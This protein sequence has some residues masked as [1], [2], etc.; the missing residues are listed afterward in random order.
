MVYYESQLERDYLYYVE[1]NPS[2]QTIT[3]QPLRLVYIFKGKKHIYT[4]DYLVI[5]TG[6]K[7]IIEI[8]PE[9]KLTQYADKF[10]M[11]KA[12]LKA[13]GFIFSVVTDT[14]IRVEPRL[15]NLKFLHRYSRVCLEQHAIQVAINY[16]SNASGSVL[17]DDAKIAL[18]NSGVTINE[19]YSMMFHGI[20]GFDMMVKIENW[21]RVFINTTGK[22]PIE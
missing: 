16:F 20:I 12:T 19:F 17:I 7:H 9:E 11:I 6:E 3:H 14:Y 5:K 4:P 18:S 10:E 13:M 21:S 15:S 8:K 2:I 22:K 1:Y